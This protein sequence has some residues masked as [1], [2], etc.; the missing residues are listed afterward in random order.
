MHVARDQAPCCGKWVHLPLDPHQCTTRQKV[1]R[2]R[3]QQLSMGSGCSS[4]HL[5]RCC[6]GTTWRQGSPL[7]TSQLQF[8]GGM[9]DDPQARVASWSSPLLTS[10]WPCALV[11]GSPEDTPCSGLPSLH[12]PIATGWL[13]RALLEG[14]RPQILKEEC[15]VAAWAPQPGW[16]N[17]APHLPSLR[18]QVSLPAWD[19]WKQQQ[20]LL[21]GAELLFSLTAGTSA[22]SP[23]QPQPWYIQPQLSLLVHWLYFSC[24][25]SSDTA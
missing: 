22:P 18:P 9:D 19:N 12:G 1:R 16:S 6:R 2:R 21:R 23:Y 20:L 10:C 14:K 7:W 3:V 5:W 25:L 8:S 4:T 15:K 24:L 11:M 13:C 17:P